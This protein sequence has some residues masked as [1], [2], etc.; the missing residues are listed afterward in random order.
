MS[1][2][3]DLFELLRDTGPIKEALRGLR[4]EP[5]DLLGIICAEHARTGQAVPDHRLGLASYTRDVALRALLAAAFIERQTGGRLSL[6]SYKPT[7][8][9]LLQWEKLK[10]NGYYVE[11][12]A[13][14]AAGKVK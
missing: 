4:E 8:T 10:A 9:G 11:K 13:S 14:P 12:H 2:V 7:A 5:A 6:F 1:A 3:D